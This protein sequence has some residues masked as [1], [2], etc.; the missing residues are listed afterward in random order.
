MSREI[1]KDMPLSLPCP[2]PEG[3]PHFKAEMQLEAENKRLKKTGTDVMLALE[4]CIDHYD[5]NNWPDKM[6]YSKK[7]L[8]K[9][10]IRFEELL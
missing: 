4:N 10:K 3:C 1:R 5:D 7:D 8:E 9:A 2:D 6:G